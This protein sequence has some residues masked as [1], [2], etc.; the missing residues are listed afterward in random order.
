MSRHLRLLIIGEHVYTDGYNTLEESG[1]GAYG[2]LCRA[3]DRGEAD[4]G[5]LDV[6]DLERDLALLEDDEAAKA[7]V[8]LAMVGWKP[9]AIGGVLNPRLTQGRPGRR[10][11]EDGILLIGV[12]RRERGAA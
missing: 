11:L 2:I 4:M 10:L 3:V 8:T 1:D 12:R 7:A 9:A 5:L 6:I